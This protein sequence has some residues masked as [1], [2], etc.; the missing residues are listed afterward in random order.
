LLAFAASG[1]GVGFTLTTVN[2]Y[3]FD[4]FR[5]HADAAINGAHTLV[6]V[7]QISAPLVLSL[8]VGFE[9]WWMAPLLIALGCLL[10][11][12][13]QVGLSL[14]LSTEQTASGENEA[15]PEKQSLGFRI[16]LFVGIVILYGICEATF[17]NWTA[18]YLEEE[19]GLSISSA[20][21][22]LSLFWGMVTLGRLAFTLA[23]LRLNLRP[24]FVLSPFFVG[25]IFLIWPDL[26]NTTL[27]ILSLAL[28]GLALSFYFPFTVSIAAAEKPESA[29]AISGL[30][31]GVLGL[32]IG[33]SSNV[34][35]L[36]SES[37]G[38]PLAIRLSSIYAVLMGV[39]AAYLALSRPQ[40]VKAKI[41]EILS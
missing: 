15:S 1:M 9:V 26:D 2:A 17:G 29:A 18:I 30:T 35:G 19:V 6:G 13:F 5:G 34:I 32:G 11:L 7:G 24:L 20:G 16:W 27:Y 38:L 4:F 37:A 8:F 36:I 22:A 23:S 12:L 3:A 21:L 10:L 39:T 31:V 33:Y 40:Q 28:G 41:E 14:R 25:V